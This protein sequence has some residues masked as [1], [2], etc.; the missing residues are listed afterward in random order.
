MSFA[1]E[2]THLRFPPDQRQPT[3]RYASQ[4][5]DA[6]FGCQHLLDAACPGLADAVDRSA[7]VGARLATDPQ[8]PAVG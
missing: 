4:V 2:D 5:V 3:V 7:K 8:V 6:A 1:I